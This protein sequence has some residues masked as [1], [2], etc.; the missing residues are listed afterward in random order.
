[1]IEGKK[2]RNIYSIVFY[3]SVFGVF[4]LDRITKWLVVNK[5]YFGQSIPVIKKIFHFTYIE[6][7]GAAFGIFPKGN[8]FFVI[9]SFVGMVMVILFY[10]KLQREECFL[11]LPLGLIF[12][13]ILG[14]L[15]DRLIKGK[16]V[17]F[18]DFLIWPVFNFAD[19]FICIGFLI[20]FLL[21]FFRK[22]QKKNEISENLSL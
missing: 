19:S 15:F 10:R 13:G 20:I 5:M 11:A 3:I 18:L 21:M 12:G 8:L 16:V 22:H 17:D 4:F 1:M 14:N 7:S 9:L 6:N 2:K